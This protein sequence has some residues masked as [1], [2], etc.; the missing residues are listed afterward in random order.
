MSITITFD[1]TSIFEGFTITHKIYDEMSKTSVI[2]ECFRRLEGV[3]DQLNLSNLKRILR[4]QCFVI[5]KS[6]DN[7]KDGESVSISTIIS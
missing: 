6:L 2:I 3:L 7:I 5:H 1:N 4:D